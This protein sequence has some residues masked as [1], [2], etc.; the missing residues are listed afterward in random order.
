[1]HQDNEDDEERVRGVEHR[2]EQIASELIDIIGAVEDE[3]ERQRLI[4]FFNEKFRVEE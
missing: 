2:L 1:M 3:D 4:T